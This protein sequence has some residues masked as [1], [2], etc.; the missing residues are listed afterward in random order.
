MTPK[1]HCSTVVHETAQKEFKF[2]LTV[3]SQVVLYRKFI[4][5]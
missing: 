5:L 3:T 1:Q 4:N 2:F